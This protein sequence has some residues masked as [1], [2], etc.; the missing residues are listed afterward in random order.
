ML[1]SGALKQ[2]IIFTNITHKDTIQN[3]YKTEKGL[4]FCLPAMVVSTF[5]NSSASFSVSRVEKLATDRIHY[6]LVGI[7]G[8]FPH[9]DHILTFG[10]ILLSEIFGLMRFGSAS[11]RK[12]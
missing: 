7:W 1:N 11:T 12:H 9:T 4:M 3:H 5:K 2:H 10:Q 6:H 8:Y